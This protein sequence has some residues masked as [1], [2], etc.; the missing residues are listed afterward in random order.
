MIKSAIARRFDFHVDK[1]DEQDVVL[2]I[3][4]NSDFIGGKLWT[5]IFA[6]FIAPI[7]L[8]GNSTAAII[9]VMLISPLMGPTMGMGLRIE[10]RH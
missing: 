7:G 2:F 8:N 3:K 5:L 10:N 4:K 1:A 9:G 6:I